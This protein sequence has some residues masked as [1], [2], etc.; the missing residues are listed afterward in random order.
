MSSG[1]VGLRSST[2][3]SQSRPHTMSAP[4]DN[5]FV[6]TLPSNATHNSPAGNRPSRYE[7][8]LA[9]PLRLDGVWKAA[10]INF[11][12]P[13]EW[14]SLERDYHFTIPYPAAGEKLSGEQ[15]TDFNEEQPLHYERWA[16]FL[17]QENLNLPD[18]RLARRLIH[19]SLR[20]PH[21]KYSDK[22]LCASDCSSPYETGKDNQ[23]R[24][25]ASA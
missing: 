4:I 1:S 7:T 12:Y 11:T 3:G 15:G 17:L 5:E 24:V 25:G 22:V 16:E 21:W 14:S 9:H 20:A 2:S 23:W 8:R 19:F 13:H 10:L 6:I 18:T